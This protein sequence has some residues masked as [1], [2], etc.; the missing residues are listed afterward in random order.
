MGNEVSSSA[1][2]NSSSNIINGISSSCKIVIQSKVGVIAT[3]VDDPHKTWSQLCHRTIEHDYL[4]KVLPLLLV[5]VHPE[6]KLRAYRLRYDTGRA[7]IIKPTWHRSDDNGSLDEDAFLDVNVTLRPSI[8]RNGRNGTNASFF[9]PH[10]SIL[11]SLGEEGSKNTT[12]VDLHFERNGVDGVGPFPVTKGKTRVLFCTEHEFLP[13][14][15]RDHNYEEVNG[16]NANLPRKCINIPRG[17]VEQMEVEQAVASGGE[18]P[19][20]ITEAQG[21]KKGTCK[22]GENDTDD[23]SSSARKKDKTKKREIENLKEASNKVNADKGDAKSTTSKQTFK[24]LRKTS[25]TNKEKRTIS[26]NKTVSVTSIAQA[27]SSNSTVGA[28]KDKTVMP[29]KVG[30][31]AKKTSKTTE[32]VVEDKKAVPTELGA[33]ANKSRPNEKNKS[34]NDSQKVVQDVEKISSKKRPS[35]SKKTA[36]YATESKKRAKPDANAEMEK[37]APPKSAEEEVVTD[38]AAASSCDIKKTKESNANTDKQTTLEKSIKE[39]RGVKEKSKAKKPSVSKPTDKTSKQNLGHAGEQD[40][41]DEMRAEGLPEG[42]TTRH[43][44]RP[45]G[46]QKDLWW[47]SPKMKYP[48][49][50]EKEVNRFLDILKE[51]GGDED[52]AFR[53]YNQKDQGKTTVTKTEKSPIAK[54]KRKRIQKNDTKKALGEMVTGK[55]DESKPPAKKTKPAKGRAAKQPVA[56]D[57]EKKTVDQAKV[58]KAENAKAKKVEKTTPGGSKETKKKKVD[59]NKPK[60]PKTAYNLWYDATRPKVKEKYPE[61]YNIKEFNKRLGVIYRALTHE[62]SR[63]YKEKAAKAME[64]Y[65]ADM[66][67]YEKT[68]ESNS[69]K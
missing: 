5:H 18:A 50:S 34:S 38:K 49:R 44:A 65:K 43:V 24:P 31:A 40:D 22:V 30:G 17:E 27:I 61:V 37:S 15:I 56:R 48:F 58:G 32:Q 39:E 20:L 33:A 62:E 6:K 1:N 25:A 66:E 10:E 4:S 69:N 52:A 26:N 16:E 47:H 67:A 41:V 45:K 13:G 7:T 2:K 55:D 35:P 19:G 54:N 23:I 51:T 3:H 11:T 12:F 8:S 59:P 57:T 46:E 63:P 60:R 53:Q 21:G 29:S 9:A 64:K 42:W 14:Y 68:I 36:D 28:T